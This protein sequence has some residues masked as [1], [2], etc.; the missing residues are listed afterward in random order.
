MM[1]GVGMA[2]AYRKYSETYVKQ[3]DEARAENRGL[4][5]AESLAPWDWRSGV[6]FSGQRTYG[7]PLSVIV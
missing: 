5:D 2:L 4:W 1:V 3:E 6:R 7:Y